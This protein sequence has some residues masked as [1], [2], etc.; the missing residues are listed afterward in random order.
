MKYDN[1]YECEHDGGFDYMDPGPF[2][3]DIVL[4]VCKKCHKD[5]LPEAPKKAVEKW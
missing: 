1:R 4:K 5:V 2:S 3:D